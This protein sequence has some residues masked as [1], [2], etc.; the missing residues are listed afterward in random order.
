MATN[1]ETLKTLLSH[2]GQNSNNSNI[3]KQYTHTCTHTCMHTTCTVVLHGSLLEIK[4]IEATLVQG[5]LT[6]MRWPSSESTFRDE[7]H[8][9]T[10]DTVG[11]TMHEKGAG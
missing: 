5:F 3:V 1:N 11:R 8:T 6:F 4:M 7:P 10:S 2:N 9:H